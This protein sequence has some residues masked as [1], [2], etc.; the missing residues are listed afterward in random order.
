MPGQAFIAA[1][2]LLWRAEL[3]STLLNSIQQFPKSVGFVSKILLGK[4]LWKALVNWGPF[5]RT[6]K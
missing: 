4:I 3:P 2:A 5:N 6:G 1:C